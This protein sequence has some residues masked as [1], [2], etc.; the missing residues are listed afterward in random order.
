MPAGDYGS[1]KIA[2]DDERES[3]ELLSAK[4]QI[5]AE[6]RTSSHAAGCCLK[7]GVDDERIGL[8]AGVIH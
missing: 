5:C 3:G 1:D 4:L 6:L 7:R 2:E 8:G